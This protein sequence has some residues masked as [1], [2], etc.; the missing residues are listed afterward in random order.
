[1]DTI[2]T[3]DILLFDERPSQ[4]CWKVL[5]YGIKCVTN[6]KYS[7]S[8]IALRDP[9]FLGANLKGLYVWESTAFNGM[10]DAVDHIQNKFG[11][12]VQPIS[13]YIS[14]FQGA[15]DI[16]VRHAGANARS[17]FTP[18]FITRMYKATY[19][20]P[21]DLWPVDWMEAAMKIG[22]RRV[23]DRFWCSAFVTYILTS[24]GITYA[25]TDW[26]SKSPQDLSSASHAMQWVYPYGP[27]VEILTLKGG[28]DELLE[29]ICSA[30]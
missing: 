30:K 12:Q 21:Y 29:Q 24:A 20:R 7:H 23:E 16:Y 14:K 1:M 13:E 25:S 6:S 26:S 15:C 4:C 22:P 3:G 10:R 5:D 28:E 11:V 19:D 2:Q 17:K 27:D 8:A 18:D 9:V